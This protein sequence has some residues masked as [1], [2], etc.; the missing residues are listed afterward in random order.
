MTTSRDNSDDSEVLVVASMDWRISLR[1]RRELG[2]YLRERVTRVMA[3]ADPDDAKVT[4]SVRR[5]LAGSATEL[6]VVN[7]LVG[8]RAAWARDGASR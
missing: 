2:A 1:L 8:A 6:E 7:Q 3:A 5:L 4:A